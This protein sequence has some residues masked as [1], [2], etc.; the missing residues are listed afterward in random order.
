M[1]VCGSCVGETERSMKWKRDEDGVALIVEG[2]MA[3]SS[4]GGQGHDHRLGSLNVLGRPTLSAG[5][6]SSLGFSELWALVA[7]TECWIWWHGLSVRREEEEAGGGGGDLWSV[8]RN[9]V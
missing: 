9:M 8:E 3:V 2:R 4:G 7:S 6:V 5:C 1:H